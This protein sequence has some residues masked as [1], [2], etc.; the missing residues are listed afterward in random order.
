MEQVSIITNSPITRTNPLLENN[1]LLKTP[2]PVYMPQSEPL[3]Y[4]P[5]QNKSPEWQNLVSSELSPEVIALLSP[6][7]LSQLSSITPANNKPIELCKCD[8]D[9]MQKKIND[10]CKNV[11]IFQHII[12]FIQL[13]INLIYKYIF[14]FTLIGILIYSAIDYGVSIQNYDLKSGLIILIAII[15]F[16]IFVIIYYNNIVALNA[17]GIIGGNNSVD[18][19]VDNPVENSGGNFGINKLHPLQLDED[20]DFHSGLKTLIEKEIKIKN[21]KN[22]FDKKK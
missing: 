2:E 17:A 22:L 20:D 6:E 16:I 14:L 4:A 15:I 8:C 12:E 19:P 9:E 21:I 1:P 11:T 13:I 18:N 3:S 7:Q 10:N 5:V